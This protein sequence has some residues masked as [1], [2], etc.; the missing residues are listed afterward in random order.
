MERPTRRYTPSPSVLLNAGTSKS[1]P[2]CSATRAFHLA[3]FLPGTMWAGAGLPTQPRTSGGKVI[4]RRAQA[5]AQ[6]SPRVALARMHSIFILLPSVTGQFLQ[7]E[8]INAQRPGLLAN[9]QR[10]VGAQRVKAAQS[11]MSSRSHDL[12]P[13]S[14]L[15]VAESTYS[16]SKATLR[17]EKHP[18]RSRSPKSEIRRP[19]SERSPNA[20]ARK[21]SPPVGSRASVFF[22]IS[23]FSHAE[24]TPDQPP[25]Y[26]PE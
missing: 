4:I 24:A 22:R 15:R 19:T 12:S 18:G 6:A 1:P 26:P 23:G 8:W 2:S 20:E 14:Y 13:C 9:R 7:T 3:S 17:T 10:K 21:T 5:S 25:T 16:R 11:N